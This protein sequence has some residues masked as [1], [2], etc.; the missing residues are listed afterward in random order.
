MN[1]EIGSKVRIKDGGAEGVVE[2]V[3]RPGRMNARYNVRLAA[4]IPHDYEDGC[5]VMDCCREELEEVT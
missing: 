5:D 1:I 3:H 2:R 4:P